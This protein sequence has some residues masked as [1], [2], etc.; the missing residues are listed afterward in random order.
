[1]RKSQRVRAWI[2]GDVPERKLARFVGAAV[3]AY[4]LVDRLPRGSARAAAWAAYA[5]QTY[6]DKL[7]EASPADGYVPGDTAH[8]ACAAFELAAGCLD[9]A[10]EDGPTGALPDALPRWNTPLRSKEQLDGMRNSLEALWIYLAFELSTRPDAVTFDERL[11]AIDDDLS[12]VRRLWMPHP[13]PEICGGIAGALT[14]GLDRA[15]VLGLGVAS[16]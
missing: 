16:A 3:D 2:R 14:R 8:V 13:P 12:Y 5:F 6:G 7:I 9:V 15:Y 1:V 4:D 11:T 10:H